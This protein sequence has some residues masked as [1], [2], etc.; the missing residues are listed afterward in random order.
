MIKELDTLYALLADYMISKSNKGFFTDNEGTRKLFQYE[1]NQIQVLIHKRVDA[2]ELEGK[3]TE[4]YVRVLERNFIRFAEEVAEIPSSF[5]L[6]DYA[7]VTLIDFLKTKYNAYF[8]FTLPAPAAYQQRVIMSMKA[9]VNLIHQ[10]TAIAA[11]DPR[12]ADVINQYIDQVN[13][14]GIT[15]MQLAYYSSFCEHIGK[16]RIADD[17][18]SYENRLLDILLYINFNT[19]EYISYTTNKIR[20]QY[21]EMAPLVPG[22]SYAKQL[23]SIRQSPEHT[24]LCYD[25]QAISVKQSMIMILQSELEY[26]VTIKSLNQTLVNEVTKDAEPHLL[27]KMNL[28]LEHTLFLFRIF[29]EVGVFAPISLVNLFAFVKRHIGTKNKSDFS[30]GSIKNKYNSYSL[31]TIKKI[32]S[33]LFLALNHLNSKYK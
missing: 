20:Q 28:S 29:H 11:L 33:I 31:E 18:T 17:D 30:P 3:K 5:T 10:N 12:L 27:I 24:L 16:L 25:L 7:I 2:Y 8:D 14:P 13:N 23:R 15:F 32:R 19:P 21:N 26:I 1:I 6:F 9:Q 4:F 22:H